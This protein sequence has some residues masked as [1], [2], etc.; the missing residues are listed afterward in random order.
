[1]ADQGQSRFQFSVAEAEQT[2]QSQHPRRSAPSVF[3]CL[4]SRHRRGWSVVGAQWSV[5][6]RATVCP[7]TFSGTGVPRSPRH[8]RQEAAP[9]QKC[10][11]GRCGGTSVDE[12]GI[13]GVRRYLLAK[14]LG[15]WAGSG[16]THNGGQALSAS[17]A[18][19]AMGRER[20]QLGSGVRHCEMTNCRAPRACCLAPRHSILKIRYKNE[21]RIPLRRSC[22]DSRRRRARRRVGRSGL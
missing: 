15:L 7:H 11:G 12:E 17:K 8:L 3:G 18:V 4:E 2:G 5:Q 9:L 14:R 16:V 1:M 19:G 10:V 13:A 6:R 21:N 20:G 22:H